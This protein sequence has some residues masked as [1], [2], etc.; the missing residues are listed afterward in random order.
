M[1]TQIPEDELNVFKSLKEVRVVYDVGAREDSD[2]FRLCPEYTYHLFGPNPDFAA[3]I[4][5]HPNIIVNTFGLSD[6]AEKRRYYG[7]IQSFK[8]EGSAEAMGM[9]GSFLHRLKRGFLW[10]LD[11]AKDTYLRPQVFELR[12]LDSYAGDMPVD[13]IK[14]DTEGYDYK[15]LLG[16]QNTLK[17]VK[18]VQFEYWDGVAKFVP[19]LADFDLFLMMEPKIR[20][21]ILAF[22]DNQ[23]YDA[24]LVPLTAD[25]V[26]L[27]DENLIP[28]GARGNVLGIKKG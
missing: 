27:I 8:N 13:F 28:I 25:V 24:L 12:T 18:Y 17:R 1:S 14:I 5:R 26:D 3:K 23:K 10:S 22:T 11:R 21:C 20:K 19:L 6:K 9:R 16:A 7:K 4:E 2:M 15:V